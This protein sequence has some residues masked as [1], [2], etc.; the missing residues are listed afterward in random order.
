[1]N[2]KNQYSNLRRQDKNPSFQNEKTGSDNYNQEALP[3]SH[4]QSRLVSKHLLP[5]SRR[6]S[7]DA[8]TGWVTGSGFIAVTATGSHRICTDKHLNSYCTCTKY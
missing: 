7:S 3:L 6:S 2:L 1:M 5:V 8:Y 4:K